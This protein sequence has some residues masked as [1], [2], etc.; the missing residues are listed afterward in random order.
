MSEKKLVCDDCGSLNNANRSSCE[1]CN[2]SLSEE[3]ERAARG[4]L[5]TLLVVA[6]GL[7]LL[8]CIAPGFVLYYYLWFQAEIDG[9][10]SGSFMSPAM[11]WVG[12]GVVWVV[13]SAVSA[14]YMPKDDYDLGHE[15]GPYRVDKI[16]T[17]RDNFDRAHLGLGLALFPVNVVVG[18]WRAV[19]SHFK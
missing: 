4:S 18:S 13:L 17:L 2:G 14:H 3:R 8:L 9:F 6:I 5:P 10:S 11:F 1:L 15:M 16:F 7:T 19:L 12:Y